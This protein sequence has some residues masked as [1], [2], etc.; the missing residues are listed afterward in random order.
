[1]R[2][3]QV[4]SA[5]AAM[6][7][8]AG[9][10]AWPASLAPQHC[11]VPPSRR[12]QVWLRPAATAAKCPPGGV[13]NSASEPPQHS[14]SPSS[15]SAHVWLP[16]AETAMKSP[17][18]GS[19]IPRKFP[20]QHLRVP[21]VL[22]AQLCRSPAAMALNWP[23][24]ASSNPLS[25][26]PQHARFPSARIAQVCQNPAAT[27]MNVPAAGT[28]AAG[29]GSVTLGSS[30][31]SPVAGSP[32]SVPGAP[33]SCTGVPPEH[34]AAANAMTR[35]RR[36]ARNIGI[37]AREQYAVWWCSHDSPALDLAVGAKP[38]GVR[39]SNGHRRELPAGRIEASLRFVGAPAFGCP[40]DVQPA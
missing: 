10:S 39:T 18:G 29:D 13:S 24:G 19:V 40:V 3:P 1:M 6:K 37:S 32:L 22:M 25:S 8:P 36:A 5:P 20:P 15:R 34:P 31:T 11:T 38:A 28:V 7:R 2:T 16:P 27:A 26:T 33:G 30:V 35:I 12:T 17:P 9:L 21:S 23:A 4:W 14:T